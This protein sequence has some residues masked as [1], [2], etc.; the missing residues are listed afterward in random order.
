MRRRRQATSS[1]AQ[2]W[3]CGRRDPG[4]G[5]L[6]GLLLALELRIADKLR[7]AVSWKLVSRGSVNF[8]QVVMP[9]EEAPFLLPRGQLRSPSAAFCRQWRLL[10]G[11]ASPRCHGHLRAILDALGRGGVHSTCGRWRVTPGDQ[12]PHR[13]GTSSQGRLRL[14]PAPP[15]AADRPGLCPLTALPMGPG[16]KVPSSHAVRAPARCGAP[17]V[18]QPPPETDSAGPAS[19]AL[20][21]PSP[22]CQVPAGVRRRGL[23]RPCRQGP[24]SPPPRSL[25]PVP[26]LGCVSCFCR[27]RGVS[28]TRGAGT[29]CASPG[30]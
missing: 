17:A 18:W 1:M 7:A 4:G 5:L 2:Q 11:V 9:Q 28:A 8:S 20:W 29:G 22:T 24:A 26:H 6:L 21:V 12:S 13:T 30:G 14:V 16:W 10:A 3:G 19:V 15:C 23:P 25:R 27:V